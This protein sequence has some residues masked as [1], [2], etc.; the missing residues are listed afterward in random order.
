MSARFDE[1]LAERTRIARDLH[2]TV[3]QTIQ[4]SKLVADDALDSC[5]DSGPTRHALEQLS[6]WLDQATTE[7]RAALNSLR[8]SAT[9]R[10]DLAEALQRVAADGTLQES[11]SVSFSVLGSPQ[12]MHP[13]V[14]DEM[15][16]ISYEAIRNSQRHS[17]GNR[18][19]I[20]LRYGKD[21]TVLVQD[22]GLGID[23]ATTD[24]GRAGHFGLQGMRERAAR[25]RGKLTIISSATTGTRV[26]LTVPGAIAFSRARVTL[27]ARMR[28]TL[29]RLVDR[30]LSHRPLSKR[31]G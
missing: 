14:R 6:S 27:F 19:E 2:D 16:R 9:V 22:N 28:V 23:P 18:L 7:S 25:I 15:Y 11:M 31:N 26:L 29:M 13:I 10:N 20:E 21:V 1:R 3:L 24:H 5:S 17:R 12:E 30:L 8:F 4:G